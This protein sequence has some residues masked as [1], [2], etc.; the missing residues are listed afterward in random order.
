[1]SRPF[2]AL[3]TAAQNGGSLSRAEKQLL[4][5]VMDIYWVDKCDRCRRPKKC[6]EIE[7]GMCSECWAAVERTGE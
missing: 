2:R 3:I 5:D 7:G 1:M 6:D 4:G